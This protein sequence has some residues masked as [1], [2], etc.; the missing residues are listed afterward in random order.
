VY[1]IAN[2]DSDFTSF[3]YDRWPNVRRDPELLLLCVHQRLL[4]YEKDDIYAQYLAAILPAIF[5]KRDI[6]RYE[7]KELRQMIS[8]SALSRLSQNFTE[9]FREAENAITV[10]ASSQH[11]QRLAARLE[12]HASP[13]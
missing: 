7:P 6:L 11:I 1:A 4:G 3:V 13:L 10:L 8:N 5:L 12:A 2:A 9:L